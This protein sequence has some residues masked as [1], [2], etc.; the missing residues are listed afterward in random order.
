METI[1]ARFDDYK[2]AEKA[3]GALL[4]HGMKQDD[5]GLIT[6]PHKDIEGK[7]EGHAKHG[8]TTTTASDAGVGAAKGAGVGLVVGTVAAVATLLIPGFGLVTGGAAL[9]T[10]IGAAVGTTAAGAVAGGVTGYL[11]DQ[12]MDEPAARSY[13]EAIKNGGALVTLHLPSEKVTR[14]DAEKVMAKYSVVT[15]SSG[16]R[17]LD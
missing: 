5:I 8:I 12:G 14:L 11:K 1:F 4:D 7:H 3:V 17:T 2:L 13:E 9:V 10:A 16:P 15:I 6:R